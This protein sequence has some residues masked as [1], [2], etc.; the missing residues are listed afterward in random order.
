MNQEAK[1]PQLAR[2]VRTDRE[3]VVMARPDEWWK[4]SH[5]RYWLRP[6]AGGTEWEVPKQ[7]VQLLGDNPDRQQ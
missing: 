4:G 3:G 2:D 1:P 6:V 7:F 5:G